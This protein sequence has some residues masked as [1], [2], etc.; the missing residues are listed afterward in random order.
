MIETK[1]IILRL[2]LGA[3]LGGII[4]FERSTH[5]RPAGFRTHLLVSTA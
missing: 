4:G 1:E 5:G 2:A 3:V